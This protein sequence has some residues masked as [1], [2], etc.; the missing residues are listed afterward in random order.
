MT[1]VVRLMVAAPPEPSGN[2]LLSLSLEELGMVKVDTV[3][4][5]SMFTQ[6]VTDAPSSVSIVT[7]DEIKRFGYRTLGEIVQ[8]VRGFD[9][10][11]DR[12]YTSL[13]VRGFNRLGDFGGRTLL[14]IDGHRMNDPIFDTSAGGNDFLLDV[15][16]IERVEFI[17]GPGS[18]I[19]GNNAFFGVISVVTRKPT[20]FN[21]GEVAASV[22]S[23]DTYRG[24]FSYG[25]DFANGV[26]FLLSGT[27]FNSD[28]PSSLFFPEFNTPETNHGIARGLD[29]ELAPNFFSSIRFGDISLKGGYVD[30]RKETPTA[31]F[32]T[33]F[34]QETVTYDRRGYV[35]L[36][37]AHKYSNGVDVAA[38]LHYDQYDYHGTFPFEAEPGLILLNQDSARARWLGLEAHA[39]WQAAEPIRLSLGVD[40]QRSLELRQRNYVESPYS[41][42]FDRPGNQQL[43]GTFLESQINLTRK[44]TL[45]A[46]VRYDHY[47]SFGNTVNPRVGLIYKPAEATAIKLLYGQAFRAPNEYE[48][49][50]RPPG[51]EDLA[52]FTPEKVRTLELVGEHYFN[53]QVH[54]TASLFYNRIDSLIEPVPDVTNPTV[55]RTGAR[56]AEVLGGEVE[57]EGKFDNGWLAR[58]SYSHQEATDRAT[59][60]TLTNAPTDAVKSQLSIPI[61]K[62]KLFGSVEFLYVSDRLTLKR[63]STGDTFL[64]NTTLFSRELLPNLEASASIYNVLGQKYRVPGGSEHLQDQLEQDGRTFRFKLQYRF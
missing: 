63:Q 62:G 24:R 40:W 27:Y 15:D 34:N 57:V 17:R 23:F 20:D 7:K 19:Y 31:P 50:F 59:G 4:A 52:E 61:I 22:G 28:G 16:L 60:L 48:I 37:Y 46:G 54:A 43:V 51:S 41:L 14:L 47:S 5:A 9:V 45:D 6:K 10:S 25:K 3:F 30:R 21:G 2:G 18:A 1:A 64:V 38:A 35:E 42:V 8:S 55:V 12:T 39:S 32:G 53:S 56:D 13:G 26:Q 44:L 29:S 36:D 58:L 33:V 49:N 11:Y